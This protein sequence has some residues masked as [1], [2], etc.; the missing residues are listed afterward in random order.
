MIERQSRY[1]E[2]KMIQ[3]AVVVLII[4]SWETRHGKCNYDMGV[5]FAISSE[6]CCCPLFIQNNIM[7]RLCEALML[8][9]CILQFT[10]SAVLAQCVV[11]LKSET[12]STTGFFSVNAWCISSQLYMQCKTWSGWSD[13]T[14][15]VCI[16]ISGSCGNSFVKFESE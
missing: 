11:W 7:H 8:V 9:S 12:N 5:R 16:R 10:S 14:L 4:R 15:G 2:S 3:K 6:Y 13:H 1:A